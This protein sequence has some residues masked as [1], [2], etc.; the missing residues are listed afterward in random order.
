M[1]LFKIVE[2]L[3][4]HDEED[5]VKDKLSQTLPS[6]LYLKHKHPSDSKKLPQSSSINN[7]KNTNNI[8]KIDKATSAYCLYAET[9]DSFLALHNDLKKNI[10]LHNISHLNKF[11]NESK[12]AHKFINEHIKKKRVFLNVVETKNNGDLVAEVFIDKEKQ[13]SLNKMLIEEG[14]HFSEENNKN[15]SI[16]DLTPIYTDH[17]IS[18]INQDNSNQSVKE[19]IIVK[20]IPEI[21]KTISKNTSDHMI[22]YLKGFGKAPYL[23]NS[24][25]N[26]SFYITMEINNTEKTKWGVDLERALKSSGVKLEDYIELKKGDNPS[27]NS[28]TLKKTI[29]V[30]NKLESIN[31]IHSKNDGPPLTDIPHIISSD[32]YGYETIDGNQFNDLPTDYIDNEIP[33]YLDYDSEIDFHNNI[34]ENIDNNIVNIEQNVTSSEKIT[35]FTNNE[36]LKPELLDPMDEIL[37]D[38][39]TPSSTNNTLKMKN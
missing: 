8:D 9:G 32:L 19:D 34:P 13:Q 10:Y 1:Y 28:G 4:A 38:L 25:N 29:W 33:I 24:S 6:N 30:I 23:N 35:S 31:E 12:S 3:L 37:A 15:D 16:K 20:P 14:L 2:K 17:S 36:K 18:T 26:N 27:T 39:Y 5:I 7:T 11:S 22:G 21:L